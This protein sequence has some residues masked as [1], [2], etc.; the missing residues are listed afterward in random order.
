[1]YSTLPYLRDRQSDHPALTP[2]RLY[3]FGPE[4]I[5]TQAVVSYKNRLPLILQRN[6]ARLPF[7]QAHDKTVNHMIKKHLLT[8]LGNSGSLL[9]RFRT[10]QGHCGACR[11]KWRLANTDLCP[12]GETQTMSHIVESCPLTKLS[13]LEALFATMRYI[14]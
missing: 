8:S 10:K 12:C 13:A 3:R 7:Y 1:M 4:S 11:R 14:N 5:T 2:L 6:M 9:N